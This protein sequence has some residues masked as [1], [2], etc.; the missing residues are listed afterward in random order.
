MEWQRVVE[1]HGGQ[2]G[3]HGSGYL[4]APDLV[5]TARHVV[6]G[7]KTT[8]L[9]LLEADELGFPGR[10]SDWQDAR[11]AWVGADD[12]LALLAPTLLQRPFRALAGST[13]IGRIDGRA[14]VRVHALG[15]PRAM[16]AP[17]HS[18]TLHLEA[19]VNAWSGVRGESMLLDV[20]TTKPAE[21]GGWK[22]MSGAA[23]FAGDR[24]VGVVEAVPARLDASTLRATPAYLVFQDATAAEALRDA[25]VAF[26]TEFVDASYVEK[27][28]LAG[29]WG[30]TREAYARAAVATF[31]SID[32]MGFA[33]VGAPYRK[34][35]ALEAFTARRLRLWSEQPPAAASG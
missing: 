6:E 3:P 5:L 19:A 12:D 10:V 31:C 35:P 14:S 8:E 16:A 32:Y 22:G 17:T 15:F 2:R 27:L 18:D 25:N 4:L 33:V 29:T 11:V 20:R 1:V 26:A 34:K 21:D 9:R 7:L 24:L 28:P 23:V 13:T 30:G